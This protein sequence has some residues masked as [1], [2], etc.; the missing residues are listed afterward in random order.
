MMSYFS[1]IMHNLLYLE[2]YDNCLVIR[3]KDIL[4]FIKTDSERKIED[5]FL[6]EWLKS[7]PEEVS[8]NMSDLYEE[9]EKQETLEAKLYKALDKLDKI[10]TEKPDSQ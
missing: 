1:R 4:T 5:E 2:E 3:F 10:E 8:K 9:M 6:A 7:L